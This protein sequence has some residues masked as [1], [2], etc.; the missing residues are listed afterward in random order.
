MLYTRTGDNGTSGLFGTCDR[1]SKDSPV[2]HALGAVDE[3]NSLLGFCRAYSLKTQ[4][5]DVDIPAELLTVQEILFII[6]ADVAGAQKS[7]EQTHIDHLEELIEDIE[8]KIE[9]P[10]SFVIPGAT[11]FS[12]LLDFARAV[13]RRTERAMVS[14]HEIDQTSL[15]NIT[16]VNRLSSLLYALARYTGTQNGG[17][18]LKPHY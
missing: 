13:C 4:W 5:E 17:I 12:G 14:A 15:L 16:Y 11:E 6:Q 9:N 3:I 10:Q 18:E 8:K 1:F 2:Y 7:I